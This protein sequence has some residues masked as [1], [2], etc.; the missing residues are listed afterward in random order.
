MKGKNSMI[1]KLPP[2]DAVHSYCRQCFG[3]NVFDPDVVE[4]C[5][6]NL[7]MNGPCAFYPYRLGKRPQ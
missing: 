5:Q 4:N 6:G 7:S 3:L 1:E 2:K